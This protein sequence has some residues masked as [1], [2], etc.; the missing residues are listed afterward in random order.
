MCYIDRKPF[1][2]L[3]HA[4]K[5]Y[6]VF[7]PDHHSTAFIACMLCCYVIVA[8]FTISILVFWHAYIKRN[9]KQNV[10]YIS[11]NLLIMQAADVDAFT[12]LLFL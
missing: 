5:Y 4:H 3:H 9:A 10:A 11:Y 2:F 8:M 12:I 7:V 6:T 1:N